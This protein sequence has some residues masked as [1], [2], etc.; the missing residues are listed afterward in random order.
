[1]QTTAVEPPVRRW[2]PRRT[3]LRLLVGRPSALLRAYWPALLLLFLGA[4]ADV[5]TTYRNLL[6]Y[7]IEVEVHWPQRVV[8]QMVGIHLGVPLAKAIQLAFVLAV[9]C[10]WRPWCGP[11][12]GACGFLYALAALNNHFLWL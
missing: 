6:A 2:L 5:W 8:S 1:M 7:G 10:W 3:N 4:A 9:A 11:L 12:L